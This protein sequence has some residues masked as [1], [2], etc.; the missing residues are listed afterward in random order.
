[1]IFVAPGAPDKRVPHSFAYFANEWALD[2]GKTPDGTTPV[3]PTIYHAIFRHH[4]PVSAITDAQA[5]LCDHDLWPAK[6]EQPVLFDKPSRSTGINGTVGREAGTLPKPP[7]SGNLG[8][9][10]S[11]SPYFGIF[12]K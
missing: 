5:A 4:P 9:K 8:R 10:S 7:Q 3:P 1:M 6:P 11:L 12:Y 2:L